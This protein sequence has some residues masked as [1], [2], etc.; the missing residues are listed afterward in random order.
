MKTVAKEQPPIVGDQIEVGGDPTHRTAAAQQPPQ[1]GA[2]G[3]GGLPQQF[4]CAQSFRGI[5]DLIQIHSP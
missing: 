3:A 1:L 2:R 5:G 4:P